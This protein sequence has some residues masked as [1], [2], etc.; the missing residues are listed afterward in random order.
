MSPIYA[1][2][3]L[4]LAAIIAS[5]VLILSVQSTDSSSQKTSKYGTAIGLVAGAVLLAVLGFYW[6]E[7]H[8]AERASFSK[9]L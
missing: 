6:V 7:H 5:I 4:G 2:F 3:V 8:P 9:L 1:V